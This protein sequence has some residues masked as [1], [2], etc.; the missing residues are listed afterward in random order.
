[1]KALQRKQPS[2][3]LRQE[4]QEFVKWHIEAAKTSKAITEQL[5]AHGKEEG[6]TTREIAYF[7]KAELTARGLG[8]RQ[9]RRLLP[10]EFKGKQGGASYKQK[11]VAEEKAVEK[12]DIMSVSE[13]D[14]KAATTPVS[15]TSEELQEELNAA[16]FMIGDNP[17]VIDRRKGRDDETVVKQAAEAHDRLAKA[18]KKIMIIEEDGTE[19]MYD[20]IEQVQEQQ[21]KKQT[22]LSIYNWGAIKRDDAY[23]EIANRV[24]PQ[25]KIPELLSYGESETVEKMAKRLKAI[26]FDHIEKIIMTSNPDE[27]RVMARY[28]LGLMYE[29]RRHYY[30][31]QASNLESWE[32]GN[33][34]KQKYKICE[35]C[36]RK[37]VVD[38]GK[39]YDKRHPEWRRR[40][41]K[42]CHNKEVRVNKNMGPMLGSMFVAGAKFLG[43]MKQEEK[44]K[45]QE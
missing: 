34:L 13:H 23:K 27:L 16:K 11:T 9:Q 15:T 43:K 45:Q 5:I 3:K 26:D 12:T 40:L 32:Q 1:M 31:Q 18:G 36:D 14:S 42:I 20:S 10:K 2:K 30:E 28:L 6:F 35:L 22:E 19:Q 44:E 17:Q 7:V 38:T 37:A 41:C 21:D 8:E 25:L 24:I 4:I 29:A 33:A 39:H